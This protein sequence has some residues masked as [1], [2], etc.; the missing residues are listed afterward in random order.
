MI[1]SGM[2]PSITDDNIIISLH[3]TLIYL[4]VIL[5]KKKIIKDNK[6]KYN[7][8]TELSSL[9]LKRVSIPCGN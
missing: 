5:E 4:I 3:F 8:K 9:F 1:P 2:H 7:L 6:S